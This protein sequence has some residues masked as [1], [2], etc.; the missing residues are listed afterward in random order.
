MKDTH[1]PLAMGPSSKLR[2][3]DSDCPKIF[4][5]C[6]RSRDVVYWCLLQTDGTPPSTTWKMTQPCVLQEEIAVLRLKPTL[7]LKICV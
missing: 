7:P 3:S 1:F 4:L 5:D 2:K 6:E